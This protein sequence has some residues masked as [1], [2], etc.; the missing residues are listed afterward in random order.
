MVR[1][2]KEEEY[3]FGG[4][5]NEWRP[6]LIVALGLM[7]S[8]QSQ[9]SNSSCV[10]TAK[11]LPGEGID[12]TKSQIETHFPP[13]AKQ[14]ADDDTYAEVKR[15]MDPKTPYKGMLSELKDK[16]DSSNPSCAA[17][18]NKLTDSLVDLVSHGVP[19]ECYCADLAKPKAYQPVKPKTPPCV[20]G[21]IEGGKCID[22]D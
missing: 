22:G 17:A 1:P 4:I 11:G 9:A 8:Y 18:T 14:Q 15:L 13:A 3:S 20:G 2:I 12:N 5:E 7:T 19:M 10:I 21:T 16:G 6:A